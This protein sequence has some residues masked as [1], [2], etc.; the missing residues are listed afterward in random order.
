MKLGRPPKSE[1]SSGQ[2]KN[3]SFSSIPRIPFF[4]SHIVK[5]YLCGMSHWNRPLSDDGGQA[6]PSSCQ[7]YLVID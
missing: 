2:Q 7:G 3:S 4:T 1:L 5:L 6:V